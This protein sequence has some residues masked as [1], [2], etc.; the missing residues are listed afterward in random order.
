VN[1]I[2]DIGN[3]ICEWDPEKLL[4]GIF[5][6]KEQ[7]QNAL[8]LIIEHDDWKELDRGTITLE[9]AI[10]NARSRCPLAPEK[11]SDIYVNTPPSLVPIPAAVK[12]IHN[13]NENGFP[14]YVLSNIQ[15]HTWE[16]LDAN[17]NFWSAFRGIVVSY[18]IKRIKPEREIFDYITKKYNLELPDTIF[19]D[20]LPVN[21]KAARAYG[22]T[23]MHVENVQDSIS[24]LYT[25]LGI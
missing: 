11:I 1:I 9:D 18:R 14:L 12:A 21:V 25:T 13:L 4:G 16:Y 17:Y 19:L 6:D 8:Q 24:E 10:D 2:F 5:E 22:I 3:V 15:K 20:D 7:Q 23:A